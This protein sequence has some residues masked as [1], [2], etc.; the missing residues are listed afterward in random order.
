MADVLAQAGQYH[1]DFG[2]ISL[3][4]ALAEV[5]LQSF[6]N[7]GLPLNDSLAQFLESCQAIFN[8]ARGVSQGELALF[9]NN[10][11]HISKLR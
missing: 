8:I 6:R 10:I 5:F 9:F 4:T 11:L 2:H 1:T 7:A 3:G